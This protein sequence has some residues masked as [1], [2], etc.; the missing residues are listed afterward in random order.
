MPLPR[1]SGIPKH[2][3][4]P[5]IVSKKNKLTTPPLQADD[6]LEAPVLAGF[7]WDK[8]ESWTRLVVHCK[9]EGAAPVTKKSKKKAKEDGEE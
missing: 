1:I 2:P 8:E 7:E 4:I 9:K 3:L 5:L 6:E